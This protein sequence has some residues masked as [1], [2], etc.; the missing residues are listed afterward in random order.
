[1]SQGPDPSDPPSDL[2][3]DACEGRLDGRASPRTVDRPPAS[4][5]GM[6]TAPL[7]W[8]PRRSGKGPVDEETLLAMVLSLS[9]L[10][11]DADIDRILTGPQRKRLGIG[12]RVAA[13][14]PAAPGPVACLESSGGL[15]LPTG[16]CPDLAAAMRFLFPPPAAAE[17]EVGIL[18]L[19][20]LVPPPGDCSALWWATDVR[21]E[22]GAMTLPVAVGRPALEGDPCGADPA[23]WD[24]GPD[25]GPR[26]P[27]EPPILVAPLAPPKLRDRAGVR[28]HQPQPQ[29]PA[30]G[31]GFVADRCPGQPV[32]RCLPPPDGPPPPPPPGPP[33]GDGYDRC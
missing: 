23:Q 24:W 33:A 17:A 29:P 21:V 9:E 26:G 25:P 6:P 7:D 32:P 31:C 27:A 2:R 15:I 3:G 19:P 18:S 10:A 8:R 22:E 14:H 13:A 4:A 1:M 5:G 12:P 16:T 30:P 11:P 28:A 20:D